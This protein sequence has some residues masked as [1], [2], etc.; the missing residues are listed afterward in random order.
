[1]N[2]NTTPTSIQK[3]Y[4]RGLLYNESIHLNETVKENENFFLGK[5]WEGVNAPDLD[6]PV[7]NI[8][9]RVVNY[10]IA[11]LVSDN[12]GIKLS[13]FNR[14]MDA[15]TK[16][17]MQA[18]E[19]QV[20]QT[21]ENNRFSVLCRDVLRDAAVDGDGCIHVFFD[22]SAKTGWDGVTGLAKMEAVANTSVFFGN[23]QVHEVQSQP[24][25][26]IETR[27]MIDSV[28]EEMKANCRP[29]TEI[30]QIV[31]D[32]NMNEL[33]QDEITNDDKVTVLTKY[34][35]EK[36]KIHWMRVACGATIKEDTATDMEYYP[37]AYIS[38]EKVKNSY[39]G[40]SVVSGLLPNQM[41]INK[42]AA[43]A[44]RF[45]RQQAFPRVIYNQDK[46][47][48]WEE[49][50]RPIGVKGTPADIVYTAQN[51]YNMSGQ[52]GDYI[53]RFVTLTKDLMGAS[54]AALGN[55]KPDNTSAII[56][57]QKATAVPLELVRQSYY[58]FVEDLVRII[59]DQVKTFYGQRTVIAMS[60]AG[61]EEEITMDFA[62]LAS[63]VLEFNVDIGQA[64]YWSEMT[65][66]TNLDN[67][68][69]KQ[70]VDQ[71]TYLEGIPETALP[72]KG[73]IV[74]EAKEK[75][76]EQKAMQNMMQGIPQEGVVPGEMPPM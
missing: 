70:L 46:L 67:L 55:V 16:I 62:R 59:I 64:A 53:D 27:R 31:T 36:G 19:R 54:D 65:A 50:M 40:R 18:C 1:M 29:Q 4:E 3:E 22:P 32:T 14:K 74:A 23:P 35:K 49:G 48:H 44:Q 66:I 33:L 34:W 20:K 75:R 5:Q 11:M 25:I 37:I 12:V 8:L 30:D 10:F 57:V 21:F 45:I 24:Y 71:I 69:Q 17:Y 47:D 39:H 9:K 76:E 52:V 42:M 26:I 2:K 68:Y 6:K 58:Q 51:N 15:Q 28:K 63:Y 60:E 41:A 43:M 7:F 61:E 72:N 56:S 73:Q 13:L 38:W